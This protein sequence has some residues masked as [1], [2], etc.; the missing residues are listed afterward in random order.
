MHEASLV[1]FVL[2]AIEKRALEMGI[3]QVRTIRLVAGK[4]R[5]VVPHL[6]EQC[7]CALACRRPLF[8]DAKL[9]IIETQGNDLMI[10][11]FTGD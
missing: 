11:S 9:E 5:G 7:F 6:M 3:R 1:Q 2:N 10:D 8:K 4:D